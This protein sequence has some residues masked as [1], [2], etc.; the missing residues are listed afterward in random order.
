MVP[1]GRF[2]KQIEE[3]VAGYEHVLSIVDDPGRICVSG[4]SAGA[5]II[6]RLLLRLANM[7]LQ[8]MK[9]AFAVLISPWVTLV[10]DKDHNTR[11]DYLDIGRLHTLVHMLESIAEMKFRP[12]KPFS[13]QVGIEMTGGGAVFV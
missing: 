3:A 7:N 2:P 6:L 5:T 13:P 12:I 1:E 8:G 11:S 10:S 4:D 9:P